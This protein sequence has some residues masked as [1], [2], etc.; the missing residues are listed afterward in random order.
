MLSP[1]RVVADPALNLPSF[2]ERDQVVPRKWVKA[3]YLANRLRLRGLTFTGGKT[4]RA[5]DPGTVD[6]QN[7]SFRAL[8]IRSR[9]SF[10]LRVYNYSFVARQEPVKVV[11][12][13]QRVSGP[14]EEQPVGELAGS[15]AVTPLPSW[16]ISD[17]RKEC[18]VERIAGRDE[19]PLKDNWE[20]LVCTFLTP[21][22]PTKGYLHVSLEGPGASGNLQT[23]NDHGVLP[24]GFYDPARVSTAA[25]EASSALVTA[26][27]GAKSLEVVAGTLVVRPLRADGSAGEPTTRLEPGRTALVE[28]KVRYTDPGAPRT[29]E[30][31][32][33]NVHL[34]DDRGIQGHRFVPLLI[35]GDGG[36]TVQL[37]YTA[38]AAEGAVP[39]KLVVTC[40][41]LLPGADRNPEGR[42]ARTVL[43]VGRP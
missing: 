25:R 15:T 6:V 17:T 31:I 12:R 11:L 35:D 22:S 16:L 7:T 3:P 29:S 38:P 26:G 8:P 9:I 10:A 4:S 32:N 28:A 41:Q 39:L 14:G 1:Y 40:T 21:D 42:T 27:A 36:E 33:V 19:D 5:S 2:Y 30:L 34:S 18:R 24:V 20:D 13:F 43:Q 23:E 37:R